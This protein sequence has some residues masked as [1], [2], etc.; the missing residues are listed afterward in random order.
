[1]SADQGH[2]SQ[3]RQRA[4]A[5]GL[6]RSSG[7]V[8]MMTMLSRVLGLVRDMVI[9]RYFGAGT[10]ADAFF[11]AFKI[12][13][14]LRRLFAEG[15]FSQA[16][17]PV[18]SSYRETR[19]ITEVRRLVNAVSGTLGLVLLGVTLVAV[20]GAPALTAVFA[21]GFLDEP[22]KFSLASDMLRITFPYLLLI[23]LTAFAGAIL[24]SYDRFAIPAF[25]P[26]LLNLAMICAAVFLSP[27]METPVLALAWGV[28]IAGALQLFF[29]LPFLM[30]LGLLPRPRV[31]YRH[32]GVRRVLK[33]MAPALFGVSVSQ[34]NLL[35]DTVL[36]SLLQTGSVSWLY[37]SDRLSELPLGVFGIAI[38]TVILP[39]LSRKH[40][41]ASADQFAATLDWAV[42]AVLLIGAPAALALALLAEPLIATLFHYGEVTDRDV[43]MAGASLRAYAAGLMAF[44]LIKVL[45]PGFFARQD[46]RTPVRIGVIAMVANMVFNL[47]LIMPL[48]HV[49]LALATALSAWLN[50]GLLWRGLKREGAWVSQPG[51][52]RFGAQLLVANGALAVLVL[53]LN[54]SVSEW[55][56]MPGLARAGQ[57]AVLV[58]AGVAVYFVTLA[59]AGVR[60]RHFR[61]R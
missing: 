11:V 36:A 61:H 47:A 16:F 49:G 33:L 48:A 55:L 60:V 8:G 38:A 24:N 3:D 39:S 31:D 19:D 9:A 10:G 6:L 37:Y 26:V 23:S 34:I 52:W 45:A 15:A 18:L 17:V 40:A 30:R 21:P 27:V 44:M 13:N 7:L 59:L 1:M 20:I 22:V 56:A 51:W 41:A 57:M 46:T 29:Q 4:A 58:G 42:R 28:F 25:T 54:P 35:L 12:P 53:Y 32:E 50:A 43:M 5:P 14:F 2:S